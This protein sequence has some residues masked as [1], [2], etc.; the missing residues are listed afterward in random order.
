[1]ATRARRC[2][3]PERLMGKYRLRQFI[4]Y[5]KKVIGLPTLVEKIVK[6][7]R[8]SPTYSTQACFLLILI[9]LVLRSKSFNQF[10]ARLADKA[11]RKLIGKV[12]LPACVDTLAGVLKLMDLDSL[13]SL[14]QRII[15][16][17]DRIKAFAAFHCGLIFFGVDGFEPIRSRKRSCDA[18][19]TATY[20]T[21]EGTVIDH[22]HRY[23]FM[24]T[25]G[26]QPQLILGFQPQQS[27]KQRK[28][29]NAAAVKAEGELTAVK[30]LI[31]RLRRIFP[32]RKAVGVGDAL[33]SNGPMVTFMKGGN[34]SYEF[35]SVLKQ[36]KNEPMADAIRLFDQTP[37]THVFYDSRRQE[38]V[39]LWDAEGF[40]GLDSTT[41]PL[42]V[43]KAQLYSGPDSMPPST[44][45]WSVD[46][47]RQWWVQTTI[48]QKR[49]SGFAVLDSCRHRWDKENEFAE[50]TIHWAIKHC[51]LH[52]HVGTTALMYIFMIGFNLF[53]LFFYR[54]LRHASGG[55]RTALAVVQDMW[56]DYPQI[57]DY[58]DGF[59]LHITKC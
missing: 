57:D 38:H 5:L 54:C 13:E 9:M 28:L 15:R 55:H 35:I 45:P 44:I 11:I 10:E 37:P 26:P 34:P 59:N 14:H 18:C 12:A 33:Y 36:E 46:R 32:R 16:I 1:M 3:H 58:G 19:Q 49:L 56:L 42:R 20:T 25:L 2:Q 4:A 31:D 51:F 39:R 47:V 50:L 53:Q 27:L 52:H 6:D 48:P 29:K 30:P 24:S 17:A 41:V 7:S 23:V 21:A 22:F 43:I 40:E 8:R